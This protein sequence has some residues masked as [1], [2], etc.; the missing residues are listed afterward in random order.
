MRAILL[1]AAAALWAGQVDA[2]TIAFTFKSEPMVKVAEPWDFPEIYD[3]LIGKSFTVRLLLQ[4]NDPDNINA[5][6]EW[7]AERP[8]DELPVTVGNTTLREAGINGDRAGGWAFN[9]LRITTGPDGVHHFDG[10]FAFEGPDY[11]FG[12]DWFAVGYI[13]PFLV[14]PGTWTKA[15]VLPVPAAGWMLLAGIGALAAARRQRL[16]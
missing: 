15:A 13:E 9:E 11:L 8:R 3:A 2:A 5:F 16:S 10:Y 12:D 1:A 4:T 7:V 6:F 14:A